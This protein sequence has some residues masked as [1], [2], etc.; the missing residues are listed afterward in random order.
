MGRRALQPRAGR[1]AIRG[2]RSTAPSR[3]TSFHLANAER[4]PDLLLTF[5]WS[6]DANAFGVAGSDIACTSGGAKLYASDHGSMSPWNVRSTCLAWGVDF[7][8]GATAPAPAGNVDVAP[9]ILHLLGLD[10]R[11]GIDGRV[12]TEALLDGPDPDRS[13]C[14]RAPRSSRRATIARRC[15][16]PRSEARRY[17]D[18]SWR[19]I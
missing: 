12:L 11:A 4:A 19:I 18:K 10:D 5:P 9:T 14:R 1:A 6:S 17:V 15:R 8:R 13:W 16:S 7:K 2:A 3:W